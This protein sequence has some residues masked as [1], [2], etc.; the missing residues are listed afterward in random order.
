MC[1]I[2]TKNKSKFQPENPQYQ[3]ILFISLTYIITFISLLLLY[4]YSFILLLYF[5]ILVLTL[6]YFPTLLCYYL[7]KFFLAGVELKYMCK[8]GVNVDV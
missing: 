5:P 2:E 8:A 6:F 4:H 3:L 7:H 1:Y